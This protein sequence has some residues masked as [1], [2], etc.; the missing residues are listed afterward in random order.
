[1]L[2]RQKKLYDKV[3]YLQVYQTK[4]GTLYYFITP[5]AGYEEYVFSVKRD[6][7]VDSVDKMNVQIIKIKEPIRSKRGK[8][9]KK[10]QLIPDQYVD[11]LD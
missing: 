8:I 11:Y 3:A 2:T 10:L 4:P 6:F 1:M 7:E 9:I 5:R